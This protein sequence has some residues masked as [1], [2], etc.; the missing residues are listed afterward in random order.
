MRELNSAISKTPSRHKNPVYVVSY[1][2]TS[3]MSREK[4]SLVAV[5]VVKDGSQDVG[6]VWQG[7][8][9]LF[10]FDL[11]LSQAWRLPPQVPETLV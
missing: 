10:L 4:L 5:Q 6:S 1:D 7:S 11:C 2:H 3:R 9:S 8:L